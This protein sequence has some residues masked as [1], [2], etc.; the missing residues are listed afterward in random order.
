MRTPALCLAALLALAAPA[1][2]AVADDLGRTILQLGIEAMR[3][4]QQR[5]LRQRQQAPR[6]AA[7]APQASGPTAAERAEQRARTREIQSALNA[8]G[9]DAGPVDG[10]TGPRTRAAIRAFEADAGL[11]VDGRADATMLGTLRATRQRA[12]TAAPTPSNGPGATGGALGQAVGGPA[13]AGAVAV[14]GA[15]ADG[16]AS[17]APRGAG[18]ERRGRLVFVGGRLAVPKTGHVELPAEASGNLDRAVL[19]MIVPL[20]EPGQPPLAPL[21]F[22][23]SAGA[24]PAGLLDEATDRRVR[25][26]ALQR[27]LEPMDM[28]RHLRG[29]PFVERRAGRAIRAALPDQFPG[30]LPEPLPLRVYCDATLDAYDFER[31]GFPLKLD[32]ACR[33]PS[34]KRAERVLPGLEVQPVFGPLPPAAEGWPRFLPMPAAEAEAFV[35]ATP[36]RRLLFSYATD[37]SLE[38]R[39]IAAGMVATF[40]FSPPR[41]MMLHEGASPTEAA[42]PQWT[43][44]ARPAGSAESGP[45]TPSEPADVAAMLARAGAPRALPADGR[46]LVW[47]DAPAAGRLELMSRSGRET[48]EGGVS[49]HFFAGNHDRAGAMRLAT[50]LAVPAENVVALAARSDAVAGVYLLLPAPARGYAVAAPPD[51]YGRRALSARVGVEVTGLHAFATQGGPPLLVISAHPREAAI[52]EPGSGTVLERFAFDDPPAA[53]DYDVLTP[54]PRATLIH[55]IARTYGLDPEPV[56][57]GYLSYPAGADEIA[58]HAHLQDVLSSARAQSFD[59]APDYWLTG[60][61]RL[62]DYDPGTQ[63][64]PISELSLATPDMMRLREIAPRALRTELRNAEALALRLPSAE[65]DAFRARTGGE[66]RL[67][68]RLQVRPRLA[69]VTSYGDLRVHAVALSGEILEPGAVPTVVDP[70]RVLYRFP[71]DGAAAAAEPTFRRSRAEAEAF[72]E[73]ALSGDGLAL[74][75]RPGTEAPSTVL[76]DSVQTS[77]Y[78]RIVLSEGLAMPEELRL[79]QSV[80]LAEAFRREPG[81]AILLDLDQWRARE[82]TGLPRPELHATLVT[83]ATEHPLEVTAFPPPREAAAVAEAAALLPEGARFVMLRRADDAAPVVTAY[84]PDT[85]SGFFYDSQLREAQDRP[86]NWDKLGRE[87][88]PMPVPAQATPVPLREMPQLLREGAGVALVLPAEDVAK[89]YPGLAGLALGVRAFPPEEIRLGIPKDHREQATDFALLG[90]AGGMAREAAVAALGAAFG[91]DAVHQTEAG[92]V[93]AGDPDCKADAPPEPA[94]AE[95][96]GIRCMVVTFREGEVAQATLRQVIPGD[97]EEAVLDALDERYGTGPFTRGLRHLDGGGRRVLHGWGEALETGRDALGRVESRL[98]PAT[99]EAV[100][101]HHEGLTTVA[102]RLDSPA[103]AAETASESAPVIEF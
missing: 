93:A 30:G 94:T 7:P 74:L 20:L 49:F 12:A 71:L 65:L 16:T 54:R 66:R 75:R 60:A 67:P 52:T 13:T 29:D 81:A 85:G 64:F 90:V 34:A 31:S 22:L 100:V 57:A 9:Y 38:T 10:I 40:S 45:W 79:L 3:L 96:A 59:G 69:Q 14:Q 32:G 103:P 25:E 68:V 43:S 51:R 83:L 28:L 84:T 18:V 95:E 76:S 24:S 26:D 11:P 42:Y 80:A 92:R 89:V 5:V 102:V 58:R 21:S 15:A 63:S 55:A 46:P 70:E 2:P 88:P 4:E 73:D 33:Q 35:A 48:A 91:A 36:S 99:L 86:Y 62:G 61:V 44:G 27:P 41:D 19:N 72:L 53:P 6:Q 39:K 37:L 17:V 1:P 87:L 50:A 101:W 82:R 78:R 56:I 23:E 47:S 97:M 8:L 98:P 77:R